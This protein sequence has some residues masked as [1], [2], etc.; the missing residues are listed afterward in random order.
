[1]QSTLQLT[2]QYE[3][4][5]SQIAYDRY[6]RGDPVVFVH[7]TPFSSFVWRKFVPELAKTHQVHVYDLLGYGAS[8][9]GDNQDVSLAVQPQ[10]LK[11][12]LLHWGL[13]SP[14]IIAHDFGGTT[15]LRA[16]LLHNCDFAKMILIDVVALS[17]WGS[18]FVQH[19]RK[20][21]EAFREILDY[22]HDGILNAYLQDAAAQPLSDDVLAG[23]KAPW[24]T[25]D[26][27]RAF[28]RQIAQ[29]DQK[30]T[31]EIQE[32]YHTIRC[33]VNI[34]WG[35]D[36]KWIPIEKGRELYKWISAEQFIPIANAGYLIQEDQP[37]TLLK[38]IKGAIA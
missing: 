20:Y 34:I 4:T 27:Q 5:F 29:M 15:T 24:Q 33:P 2:Q 10:I 6:G 26:G 38:T 32:S 23:L 16:H 9:M 31:D 25:P 30:Y 13:Q 21:G 37:D 7:G 19:V 18:P 35:Q 22:I 14:T 36:D 28:Y 1:M 11:E 17:P 12:L 8:E 3:S